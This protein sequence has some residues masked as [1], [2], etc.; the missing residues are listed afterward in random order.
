MFLSNT[1]PPLQRDRLPSALRSVA[2]H[3]T[4]VECNAWIATLAEPLRKAGITAARCLA[5]F[6]G[7]CAVES[8]G[9]RSLEEDL[10]YTAERL[11]QV[12]PG[13]F[14]DTAAA[15]PCALKPEIL[16]NRIYANRMGN[17]DE[18]S[19]D[20]WQFRGRGLIQLTGRANY[21]NFANAMN[22]TLDQAVQHAGTR[23]GAVDSAVW[24][25]TAHQLNVLASSWSV[26][27]ITQRI[28]SG[29]AGA[30]ERNRL[31]EA[32]LHAIGA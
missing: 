7:Q 31:C 32:A 1:P 4:D 20:G 12:W 2:P 17:G 30:A 28:N 3:L 25:W 27:L 11:C 6:L 14:P 13:R 22:M 19:G 24:F 29:M 5:A 9:F 21:Q 10:R 16:A 26:N 8:A 23:A 18:A 15:E